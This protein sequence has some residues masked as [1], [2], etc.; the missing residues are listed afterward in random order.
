MIEVRKIVLQALNRAIFNYETHRKEFPWD[1]ADYDVAEER[2]FLKG[3]QHG[4][5]LI[6]CELGVGP[7]TLQ[8]EFD[9]VHQRLGVK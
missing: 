5:L 2:H 9:E 8:A 3:V 1:M 4:T 7:E 6:A